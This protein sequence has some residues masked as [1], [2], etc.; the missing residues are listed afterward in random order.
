MIYVLCLVG[1]KFFLKS[2]NLGNLRKHEEFIKT[3]D[4]TG[5]ITQRMLSVHLLETTGVNWPMVMAGFQIIEKRVPRR[6]ILVATTP[7]ALLFLLITPEI[8]NFPA[9]RAG[10]TWN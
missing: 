10:T 8:E 7:R 6:L 4:E 5:R 9:N 1:E 2:I 3:L